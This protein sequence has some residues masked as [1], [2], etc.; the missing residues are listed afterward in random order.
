MST[1]PNNNLFALM[2]DS[3]NS[4]GTDFEKSVRLAI[5]IAPLVH[6]QSS[7][8]QYLEIINADAL[9]EDKILAILMLGS[10]K[11]KFL[12]PLL[13]DILVGPNNLLAL[14][15]GIALAQIEKQNI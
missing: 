3:L 10:P 13:E 2:K 1:L 7:N 8:D 5:T 6:D 15:A 4:A 11:N 12:L 14:A 9:V